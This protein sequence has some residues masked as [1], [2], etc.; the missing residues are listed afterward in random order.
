MSQT[1]EL[2][3]PSPYTAVGFAEEQF[4]YADLGHAK[5]NAALLRTAKRICRHP[6][7]TLP[8]KLA[9]PNDYQSDGPPGWLTLWRGWRKLQSMLDGA[10]A[11]RRR[12]RK[13]R[14]T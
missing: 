8:D 1:E 3:E 12:Q 9:N 4:N 5:R 7:G 6:G 10:A 11:E 2:I 14:V 13:C